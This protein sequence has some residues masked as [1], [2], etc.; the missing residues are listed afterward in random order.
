M[1]DI[2]QRSQNLVQEFMNR[3]AADPAAA[4]VGMADMASIGGAFL[5]LTA[6]MM[7]EPQKL[8]EAQANLWRGYM[9]LWRNATLQALGH[10]AAAPV[11]PEASDKRFNDPAWQENQV[12]N[13]IKQSYLLTAR[14]MQSTVADVDGLDPHTKHKVEFFTR[15]FADALA[16][17]NFAVTNPQVLRAT[18]ESKGENLVKGLQNLLED[19]EKGK[20]RLRVSMTDEA[21]FK[22]GENVAAPPGK[23][24]AE[25]PLMQLIQYTPT[26]ATVKEIPVVIIPPWI[27]KFYILDLREKNSL[28]KWLTDQG[29]TTFI[30]SWVNPDAA[31][32]GTSF[33]DYM[34]QGAIAAKDAALAA[35]GAQQTHM[36]GY[37]IG[38]TLLAATLAYLKAKKDT[39]VASATYFVTLTDFS[40]PGDLG[41]FIDDEQISSIEKRMEETGYLD[42]GDMAMSFNMLRSNDLIWSFVVNNYLLGKE[43]FPFDLLYWNAD[44]TR[45]P[46]AMHSFYLRKM[47]LEN[48]LRE[49]GGLSLGGVPIDLRTVDVPTYM[50]SCREDH[51]APWKSTFAATSLFSGPT[52]FVLSGSGHIAGVVNA[53]AA[54]KYG[55]WTNDKAKTGKK[56]QTADEWLAGATEHPG[57]WWTDWEAWLKPRSGAEIPARQPGDGKLKVIENAPGRY[58]KARAV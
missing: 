38:G 46:R 19:M 35:T 53:P 25:T 47:Y 5:E 55:Y 18:A 44:S 57:S 2:A 54:K 21:A 48:K 23:V 16:P 10:E 45:M 41:V 31:L 4:G 13:F 6:K 24:V 49:P 58:V 15:Q 8:M 20:G 32:A 29:Y 42:A 9:E 26:T 28:V 12:F 51:I 37:C 11:A 36:V 27:N 3:G 50:I 43:P 1:T 22:V 56:A 33:D 52:K 7:A 39:T 34:M 40:E 17:T 30:V 14:W